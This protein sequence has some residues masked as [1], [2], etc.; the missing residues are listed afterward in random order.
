MG[1]RHKFHR[2]LVFL[3]RLILSRL[4]ILRFMS[5]SATGVL[6]FYMAFSFYCWLSYQYRERSSS[7]FEVGVV[8]TYIF[9]RNRPPPF[10]YW[11]MTSQSSFC[12]RIKQSNIYTFLKY[13]WFDFEKKS[14]KIN[15]WNVDTYIHLYSLYYGPGEG[16]SSTQPSQD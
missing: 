15:A 14:F 11:L 5:D 3:I 2:H 9:V 10:G 16:W 1:N 4:T 12:F 7:C 13:N 6:N 8:L